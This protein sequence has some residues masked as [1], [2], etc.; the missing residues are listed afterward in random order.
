MSSSQSSS[1]SSSSSNDQQSQRLAVV[2]YFGRDEDGKGHSCGYCNSKT[3]SVTYG[4]WA[5]A[6]GCEHY[7]QLIDRGWRRSGKHVYKP[8]MKVTCCPQY[9]IRCE[10]LRFR[11]SRSHKKTL[12]HF[13]AYLVQD[14]G[15]PSKG[16]GASGLTDYPDHCEAMEEDGTGSAI[17]G[18]AE[19]AQLA[20]MAATK[21]QLDMEK[22]AH[23]VKSCQSDSSQS[24]PEDPKGSAMKKLRMERGNFRQ[25]S[26]DQVPEDI[27]QKPATKVKAGAGA[28]PSL[29]PARKAKVRA[30]K[31]Y[32]SLF[33]VLVV[34]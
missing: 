27:Q 13:R 8:A 3:T 25:N 22:G 29:P 19:A 10:A 30:T 18:E 17:A 31:I 14:K 23:L 34:S 6:L 16:G 21:V 20:D 33:V 5:H 11:P 28:N 1:S 15:A 2:E 4:L 9:T 12:K 32:N 7:Q 24:K 26:V